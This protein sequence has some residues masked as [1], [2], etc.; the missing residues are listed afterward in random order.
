[1]TM[2]KIIY[3][4][5]KW[6]NA[7]FIF[8]IALTLLVLSCL[9]C[10][11]IMFY[12]Q[13][14][15]IIGAVVFSWLVWAY[16]YLYPQ[17]MAIITDE[18]IKIDHSAPLKWAD[19]V[20]AEEREIYCCFKKRKIIVLLPR[21]NLDYKYSWLQKH[22]PGFTAFSIPLYGLL[23]PRDEAEIRKIIEQHIKIKSLAK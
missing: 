9:F 19:I 4:N 12:K 5:F 13:M 16:K 18:S 17:K 15:V 22:N 11:Q 7:W 23:S 14:Y 1:M 6:F 21:D 20:A 3:Y 10:P 8:N 2:Q